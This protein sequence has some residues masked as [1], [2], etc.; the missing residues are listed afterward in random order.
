ML[1]QF[2]DPMLG[3]LDLISNDSSTVDE[4]YIVAVGLVH[5]IADRLGGTVV[6]KLRIHQQAL[7]KILA[8]GAMIQAS[9]VQENV[10]AAVALLNALL[11]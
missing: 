7:K 3:L 10:S 11:Q 8:K 2:I 5:D 9:T 4:T 1:V 6:D